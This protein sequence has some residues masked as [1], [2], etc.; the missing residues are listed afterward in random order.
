MSKSKY[1]K[2]PKFKTVFGEKEVTPSGILVWP[3]LVTPRAVTNAKPAEDGKPQQPRF[4]ATLLLSKTDPK[5]KTFLSN[6]DLK[7]QDML[8]YFNEDRSATIAC[9]ACVKDGDNAKMYDPEKYPFFA[10]NWVLVARNAAKPDTWS[11]KMSPD[12]T[13][14]PMSAVKFQGGMRVKFVIT[15]LIT[16]HGISYKLNDVQF[17]SDDLTRIGG[18]VVEGASLLAQHSEPD[19]LDDSDEEA[20]EGLENVL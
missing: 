20:T 9:S 3:S 13:P 4:E 15:P 8:E 1:Y 14:E 6:L 16:G 11:D 12:G 2:H 7:T 19:L 5:N 17:V 18:G 10:G